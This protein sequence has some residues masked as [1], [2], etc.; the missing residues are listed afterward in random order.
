MKLNLVTMTDSY[1]FS[2]FAQYPNDTTYISSYIESRGGES[3]SV[4]FGPQA[5]I[6]ENMLNPVTKEQI[7]FGEHLIRSHGEPCNRQGWDDLLNKHGGYM[8]VEIEAIPEGTVLPTR[9]VQMQLVNTD[10]D[11]SWVT[12]YLETALLRSVWYPSSVAT[13]S[14]K[15][16][17]FIAVALEKSSDVPVNDQIM[18]K[19]HDFGGR[20]VSSSESAQLG[21]MAHL[22]NF[23]GT[24]TFEAI[25]AAMHYYNTTNVVGYSIPASEHSVAASY[26]RDEKAY[27]RKMLTFFDKFN[28]VASVGDTYDIFNFC[29]VLLELKDEIVTATQGG[30]TLVVRPDSGDVLLIPVQ[31]LN[32]LATNFGYTINNKGYKVL[33]SYLRVIQGD[34]I[35]EET[36]PQ[37]IENI[38]IA[39]FSLENIAFGMGGGLLQMLNRDSLRYAMKASARCDTNG[40]WHDVFKDPITDHGKVSKKGR[41][42]LICDN[43]LTFPKFK[44]V[45]KKEADKVG[46]LLRPIFRNGELLIDDTFE[47]IRE[48]ATL[49]NYEY[50]SKIEGRY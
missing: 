28:L 29:D 2:Q 39:G 38:L 37:L 25:P 42:G 32:K 43:S 21:G 1:K 13:R 3:E 17:K 16:K 48:R 11:F 7:D 45:S 12:S 26:G 41:L 19:L 49:H 27:V 36:L 14:R 31:V 20:G 22:L 5:F 50:T 18:F 15:L 33:P 40:V 35:N 30:K 10:P 4:F 44:T 46:N 24:D 9:N 47:A 23:M 34:G 6:K 8:P